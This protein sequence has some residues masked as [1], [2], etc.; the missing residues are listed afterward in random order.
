[1]ATIAG[2]IIMPFM[3]LAT[4]MTI[5]NLYGL[6]RTAN[7]RDPGNMAVIASLGSVAGGCVWICYMVWVNYL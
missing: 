7:L 1:M 6:L 4:A 5:Y 2:Y 3:V